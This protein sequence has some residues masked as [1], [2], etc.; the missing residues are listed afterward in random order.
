MD[1]QFQLAQNHSDRYTDKKTCGVI[2]GVNVL[3][4]TPVVTGYEGANG[5]WGSC[6]CPRVTTSST[7]SAS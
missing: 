6:A 2:Y 5:P 7:P 4:E 3:P 1:L